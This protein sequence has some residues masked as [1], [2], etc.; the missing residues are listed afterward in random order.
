[1]IGVIGRPQLEAGGD[2]GP[3]GAAAVDVTLLD[4]SD[5]REVQVNRGQ[6]TRRQAET[7][8]ELGARG[9]RLTKIS[10]GHRSGF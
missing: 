8:A 1:M 7:Q 3:D 4:A 2:V 9:Q 5:F 6:A 10:E